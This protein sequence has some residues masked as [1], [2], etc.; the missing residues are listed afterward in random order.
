MYIFKKSSNDLAIVAVCYENICQFEDNSNYGITHLLEHMITDSYSDIEDK[1][2]ELCINNNAFTG[3]H[4]VVFYVKGLSSELDKIKEDYVKR[5]T[6]YKPSIEHF[7]K[8]KP[9]VYQEILDLFTNSMSNTFFNS[10]THKFNFISSGG[11]PEVIKNITFEQ[12]EDFHS[13]YFKV[14]KII[15]IGLDE[16]EEFKEFDYKKVIKQ[17]F[18]K[19]SLLVPK[20]NSISDD[21]INITILSSKIEETEDSYY[22]PFISKLL[23]FGMKSPLYQEIREKKGYVYWIGTDAVELDY[24]SHCLSIYTSTSKDN[25]EA[26]SKRIIEVLNSPE[27][28]LTEERFNLIKSNMLIQNKIDFIN[29]VSK[30]DLFLEGNRK[31]ISIRSNFDNINYTDMLKYY[32]EN[33]QPENNKYSIYTELNFTKGN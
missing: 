25:V 28:F 3:S 16:T 9:I 4:E 12:V 21:S 19:S 7:N 2:D 33:I 22:L 18:N 29:N 32:K 27:E 15:E 30:Y 10:L 1:Y 23:S 8:Q 20:P 6:N 13:K 14:T 26:V 17:P 5:V 24:F 11:I 31:N